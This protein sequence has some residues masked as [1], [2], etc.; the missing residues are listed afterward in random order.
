[1]LTTTYD[2]SVEYW[3]MFNLNDKKLINCQN[4]NTFSVDKLH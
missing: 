1:M 3:Q 4:W 2:Q